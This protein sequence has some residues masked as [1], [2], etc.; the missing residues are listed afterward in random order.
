LL[1]S[2]NV[3]YRQKAGELEKSLQSIPVEASIIALAELYVKLSRQGRVKVGPEEI[4]SL[5][6]IKKLSGKYF[7][8][9]VVEAFYL[10]VY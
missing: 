4:S 5:E 7:P 10:V 6:D 8:E 2:Y 9:K 3:H 1:Q